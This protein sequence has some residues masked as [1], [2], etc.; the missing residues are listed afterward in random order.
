MS[1]NI[2]AVV[3]ALGWETREQDWRGWVERQLRYQSSRK[4]RAPP[5]KTTRFATE[6]EAR[7]H[8]AELRARNPHPDY[9]VAVVPL[10]HKIAAATPTFD[11]T[12]RHPW[13]SRRP[14][15]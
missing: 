14:P 1:N 9:L 10:G 5:V 12:E 15:A 6:A 3:P 11:G 2:G 13:S 8:A 7:A 4:R